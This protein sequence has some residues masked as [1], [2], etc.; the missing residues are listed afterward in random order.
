MSYYPTLFLYL[1][2]HLDLVL[3]EAFWDIFPLLPQPPPTKDIHYS[4]AYVGVSSLNGLQVARLV[5]ASVSELLPHICTE[6][7]SSW[8]HSLLRLWK[9]PCTGPP[10]SNVVL[11]ATSL[12]A[13]F[14]EVSWPTDFWV[15]CLGDPPLA[16]HLLL[17][18]HHLCVLYVSCYSKHSHR[19]TQ[20]ETQGL[21]HMPEEN[22]SGCIDNFKW[23]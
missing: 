12:G 1:C 2:L 20:R 4:G 5:W 23:M 7:F 17:F 15:P 18:L 10:G 6:S 19:D 3:S 13:F 9:L 8:A 11:P 21:L 14:C 22:Q 16:F